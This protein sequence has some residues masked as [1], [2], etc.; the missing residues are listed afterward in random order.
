MIAEKIE[1]EARQD[2]EL[3]LLVIGFILF[4]LLCNITPGEEPAGLTGRLASWE[5][6]PEVSGAR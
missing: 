1:S 2:A 6:D 3:I 5:P 4:C